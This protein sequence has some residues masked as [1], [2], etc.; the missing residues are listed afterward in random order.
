[1]ETLTTIDCMRQWSHAR[2]EEGK[3]VGFVPTMGYLHEGHLSLMRRACA[4]NDVCVA[5]I[6]VNPTQFGP[7]ED[8]ESYPRDRESDSAKC[9][10]VG[11]DALFMPEAED[12]YGPGAQTTVDVTEVSLPLCGASRSGHFQGVAT[13]VLK[14]FNMVLPH[15]AYFGTKDY[16]QFQVIKTMVR[17]LNLE[18]EVIPCEIVREE[19]GL[20]MSSRNYYLS[21]DERKQ[22]VCLYQALLAAKRRF[23]EGE[24]AAENYLALMR[25]RIDRE[26]DTMVDYI[27]L[28]HPETLE[29][30]ERVDGRAL[31]A[32]AV[33]IG[34]TRLIDN[35]LM[36]G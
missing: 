25:E 8:L 16:Q 15:T 17:D 7:N 18:V 35:L 34:K 2:R 14:L 19:D 11:V 21:P 13:V 36:R 1:M 32:L 3:R 27:S 28:V 33:R 22:A 5:S 4:E 10:D 26:P 20:A 6:F 29:D 9:G 31:A 12:V 30:L 24:T 23:D